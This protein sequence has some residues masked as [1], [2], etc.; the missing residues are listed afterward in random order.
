MTHRDLARKFLGEEVVWRDEHG[1][2]VG[3]ASVITIT[4]CDHILVLQHSTQLY[5]EL[6]ETAD[7]VEV[8][9]FDD[10]Q[11]ERLP[12]ILRDEIACAT[13]GGMLC[14]AT[15]CT[16]RREFGLDQCS[17]HEVVAS[18]PEYDPRDYV[19]DEIGAQ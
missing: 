10:S 6:D 17:E 5:I 12:Q 19:Y 2:T 9:K 16:N 3:P 18:Y 1:G 4:R 14:A 7:A 15:G 11:Y 13:A 8:I